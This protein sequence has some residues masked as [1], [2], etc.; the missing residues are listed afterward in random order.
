MICLEKLE[1]NMD[2]LTI[3]VIG[4]N[5]IARSLILASHRIG[6][7]RIAILDENGNN[8][9]AGQISD[10]S[11][12]GSIQ[13]EDKIRQLASI[14][15]VITIVDENVNTETL[16][17]LEKEGFNIIPS[18]SCIKI[19]QNKYN[20][21]L[22]L[23]N[24]NITIAEF[25][26]VDSIED[27]F[28]NEYPF[29]LKNKH[30]NNYYYLI[31]NEEEVNDFILNNNELINNGKI[32]IE[33]YINY[34]KLLSTVVIKTI[35]EII[36]Y[37][38]VEI[39]QNEDNLCEYVISPC[40][41]SNICSNNAEKLVLHS[42]QTLPGIGVFSIDMFLLQNDAILVHK[43]SPK[44]KH[45]GYYT[46]NCCDIDQ[47]EMQ[48][49]CVMS[50]PCFKPN[51]KVNNSLM[52]NIKAKETKFQSEELFK[53]SFSIPGSYSY[54]YNKVP[55]T[56]GQINGHIIITGNNMN[57]LIIRSKLLND[58]NIDSDINKLIE[59]KLNILGPEVGIILTDDV[60]VNYV[61]EISNIFDKF[62][63][64]YELT[65]INPHMSPM[66][67]FNYGQTAI[68]RG[69]KIIIACNDYNYYISGMISS[70]TTLPVLSISNNSESFYR[71]A[72]PL[73]IPIACVSNHI[74]AALLS[75][76]ILAN[77]NCSH[78]KEK[79]D[80]YILFQEKEMNK[81]SLL[82]ERK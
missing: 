16:E 57:E 34:H 20:Q 66:K 77:N 17:N 14:S 31:N 82:M 52:I 55:N 74:N 45:S 2:S 24:N 27:L 38:I 13:E 56:I 44:L 19:L 37:P 6:I 79:L 7:F 75:I 15:D 60:D 49:R 3:G 9:S 18:S 76:R 59:E 1:N 68:E 63:I 4:G 70:L 80:E 32:Y 28:E 29:I 65:I 36:C 48:L 51:L 5:E 53:K 21:K 62:D 46:I 40:Q 72:I 12:E 8:S 39:I 11:I 54:W 69:L 78:L 43:I 33:K 50:L 25:N 47:F 42:I 81:K 10:L 73:T 64:S 67:M 30:N 41:I 35:N 26:N 71:L 61:K 22:H 58:L 23:N